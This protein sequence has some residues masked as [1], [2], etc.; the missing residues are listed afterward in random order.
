MF[1]SLPRCLD[2]RNSKTSTELN[3]SNIAY[4]SILVY[5]YSSRIQLSS[6]T[7]VVVKTA[8]RHQ[9]A[10][11]FCRYTNPFLVKGH[12]SRGIKGDSGTLFF[13][14]SAP[15]YSFSVL[16]PSFTSTV[17]LV[18]I[19]A[20][21]NQAMALQPYKLWCDVPASY[22]I[23]TKYWLDDTRIRSFSCQFSS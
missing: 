1:F 13:H 23:G 9:K 15:K 17:L 7:I 4:C 11:S 21:Q 14:S 2:P 6:S 22:V 19:L 10:H 18:V 20:P 3:N 12:D 5:I 16:S 8:D